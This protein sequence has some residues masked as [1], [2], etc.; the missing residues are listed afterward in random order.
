MPLKGS[1]KVEVLGFINDLVYREVHSMT[2][3]FGIF[4][5]YQISLKHGRGVSLNVLGGQMLLPDIVLLIGVSLIAGSVF[6]SVAKRL[7]IE[8]YILG[9]ISK[10]LHYYLFGAIVGYMFGGMVTYII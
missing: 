9:Q 3:G 7:D 1:D 6:N 2:W 5:I 8:N 10:E 4:F